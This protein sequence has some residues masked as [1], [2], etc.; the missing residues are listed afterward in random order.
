MRSYLE[1]VRKALKYGIFFMST[2]SP[3]AAIGLLGGLHELTV[4]LN[5]RKLLKVL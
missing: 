2:D 5:A 3:E 4:K 1:M